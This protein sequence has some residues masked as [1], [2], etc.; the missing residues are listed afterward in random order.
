MKSKAVQI[1]NTKDI[2][3]DCKITFIIGKALIWDL[4]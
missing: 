1:L 4:V 2:S 3:K